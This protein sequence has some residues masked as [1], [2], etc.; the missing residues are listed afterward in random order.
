M[1][2]PPYQYS[3]ESPFVPSLFYL[4]LVLGGGS[5]PNFPVMYRS[6]SCI[7]DECVE[8]IVGGGPCSMLYIAGA[9]N[10]RAGCAS[11]HSS[12]SRMDADL[13]EL[14]NSLYR[15][16]DISFVHNLCRR[17]WISSCCVMFL[18]PP[19]HD[20]SV[21]DLYIFSAGPRRYL[22]KKP[23]SAGADAQIIPRFISSCDQ[24]KMS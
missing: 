15:S 22:R 21:N 24:T 23:L 8:G 18:E 20:L 17:N 13:L 11:S 6:K 16:T 9:L 7:W 10:T 14:S 2:F 4:Q 3:H 19:S 12:S 5:G 1:S